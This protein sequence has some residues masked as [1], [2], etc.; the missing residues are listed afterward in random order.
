[1]FEVS[2]NFIFGVP[3]T[4]STLIKLPS[5]NATF[6]VSTTSFSLGL[7]IS[8]IVVPTLLIRNPW[9]YAFPG[10]TSTHAKSSVGV[11]FW[12][13]TWF[14]LNIPSLPIPSSKEFDTL[15]LKL[16]KE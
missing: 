14:D 13:V 5:S 8:I 1:M 7:S 6:A 2:S 16:P 11:L 10:S 9:T 3:V 12:S 4:L 15:T